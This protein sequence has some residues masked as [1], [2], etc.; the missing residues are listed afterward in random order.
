MKVEVEAVGGNTPWYGTNG[1]GGTGSSWAETPYLQFTE[2]ISTVNWMRF[3]NNAYVSG[4]GWMDSQVMAISTTPA[5]IMINS[6]NTKQLFI[7]ST[8][9]APTHSGYYRFSITF[10]SGKTC[11]YR[12]I[13]NNGKNIIEAMSE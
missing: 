9:G 5:A 6:S 8:H 3:D 11:V 7:G 10:S 2:N 1:Y 4:T 13:V 12:V